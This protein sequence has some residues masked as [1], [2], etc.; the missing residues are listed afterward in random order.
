M[1]MKTSGLGE[2]LRASLKELPGIEFAFIYG[3]VAKNAESPNSDL[4]LFVVGRVSGPELHKTLAKAKAALHREIH[5]ARFTLEEL[6]RRLGQKDSFLKDVM[7]SKRVF[8][9][10]TEREFKRTVKT[11]AA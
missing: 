9:I 3:S 4:D 1:A 8:I 2:V 7:R 11:G 5:T 10:G 6:R